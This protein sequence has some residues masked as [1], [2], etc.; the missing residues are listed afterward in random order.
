MAFHPGFLRENASL[1]SRPLASIVNASIHELFVPPLWRCANVT[2]I[3][4]CFPISDIDSDVRPISLTPIVTKFLESFLFNWFLKSID[5]HIDNLQFGSIRKSSTTMALIY[6]LH[7]WYEAMDTPS[8]LLRICMLDFSKA[9]DHTDFNILSEKLHC[10]GVHPVLINW[11]ANF[12]TDRKQRTRIE[13]HYSSWKTINPGV[14]QGTKLF[15]KLFLIMVNDL[16]V[17]PDTVK[18]VDDTT[19]WEIIRKSETFPS[20]LPAQINQC[21][22]WVSQNNMKLNPQKTK[23]KQVCYSSSDIEP[24][25]PITINGD[26]ITSVPHAKLLGV[27]SKDLKWILHM[28]YICKKTAKRL[29]ALHLL[30]RSSIPTDKLVR[31]LITCM[32]LV[33]EYSCEVWHYFLPQYLSDEIERIQRRAL[34]ISSLNLNTLKQWI[35]LIL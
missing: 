11:I 26:K 25:L 24:P 3:P 12:L 19:I 27:I 16:S 28:D 17:S 34:R 5:D 20:V 6:M 23:E 35:I 10:M 9:F 18:F 21:T 30:K 33:L 2:L 1:I 14:S 15:L 29:Y 32:R 13:N 4:K 31:I 8:T 7:K 22:N